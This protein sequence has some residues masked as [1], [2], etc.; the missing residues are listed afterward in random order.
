MQTTNNQAIGTRNRPAE[1]EIWPAGLP[2][3]SIPAPII[4]LDEV[5]EKREPAWRRALSRI[6]SVLGRVLGPCSYC[7]RCGG[8]AG[9][10]VK[11]ARAE[12]YVPYTTLSYTCRCGETWREI[13]DVPAW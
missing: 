3:A 10:T 9:D 12:G 8:Y 5:R 1:P 2:P 13:P 11:S 4:E 7:P 6:W